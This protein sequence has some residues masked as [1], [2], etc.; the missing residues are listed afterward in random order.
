MNQKIKKQWV[1]ALRSEDYDQG[2]GYLKANDKFCCFGV[3]CDIHSKNNE[4]KWEEEKYMG[5]VA[6]FPIPLMDWSGIHSQPIIDDLIDRN[7]SGESFSEIA[8]IIEQKL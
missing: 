4:E 2:I 5:N 6:L 8:D 7:D 1:E 3:L